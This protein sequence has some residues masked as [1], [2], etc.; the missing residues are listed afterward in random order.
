MAGGHGSN[1]RQLPRPF[2]AARWSADHRALLMASHIN[3]LV[4]CGISLTASNGP[5]RAE[6]VEG[7]AYMQCWVYILRCAD[8]SDY[9]GSADHVDDRIKRHNAG[10]G[11][12]YTHRRRPV[13]LVYSEACLDEA[14]AIRRE[15]QIKGWSRAKKE[16][17][18]AGDTAWLKTL[19]KRRT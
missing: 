2:D 11:T 12:E 7:W 8:G 14:S 3:T 1:L 9:V 19:S 10:D 17:L 5:E 6:R 4:A 16:A 15:R 13:T 18:I